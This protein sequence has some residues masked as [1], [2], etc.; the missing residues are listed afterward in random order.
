MPA[1]PTVI[2]YR[3]VSTEEQGDSGLW[4]EAQAAA[5]AALCER[6]GWKVAADYQDVASGKAIVGRPGLAE[7]KAHARR[8]KGVLVAA[9]VDRISR[10]VID[11]STLLRDAQQE[12]WKVTML[13]MPEADMTTAD[14]RFQAG[15]MVLLAERE[16][17]L[18]GERT[19]A[20][21]QALKARGKR[22]GPPRKTPQDVV[23][24]VVRERDAG[25][26]WPAI[27]KGLEQDGVPT[28]RGG[29]WR[30]STVQRI[31][32]SNLLDQKAAL[33]A[34]HRPVGDD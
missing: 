28:V 16:R 7:A 23:D 17:H 11:F 18:I 21:L 9:R 22:L 19:S 8:S 33:L 14:G 4:L 1:K 10:S 29:T 3:R 25:R 27:A 15:L 30:V 20:A 24:R 2:A 26:S 6:R 12:G 32:R 13:D 34:S 5:I 31:Y